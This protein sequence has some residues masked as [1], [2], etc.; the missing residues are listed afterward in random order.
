[1]KEEAG[2]SIGR[3]IA[4]ERERVGMTQVLLAEL[5]GIARDKLNKIENGRRDVSHAEAVTIAAALGVGV[6]DLEPRPE[7]IQFRG[8][9]ETPDAQAAIALFERYVDNWRTIRVL[10]SLDEG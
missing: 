6:D 4:E 8:R 3:R 2:A 7:R 10:Q 5:T 9:R 1:M